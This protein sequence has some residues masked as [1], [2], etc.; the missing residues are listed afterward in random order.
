MNKHPESTTSQQLL[1]FV[2]LVLST[3]LSSATTA[4]D[5]AF[6]D[7]GGAIYGRPEALVTGT[8]RVTMFGR[9]TNDALWYR[10]WD[11]NTGQWAAWTSLGGIMKYNPAAVSYFVDGQ[12]I[13]RVFVT[14]KYNELWYRQRNDSAWGPWQ[15]LSGKNEVLLTPPGAGVTSNGKIAVC[16][17]GS[18]YRVYCKIWNGSQWSS[19]YDLGG[20]AVNKIEVVAW[21]T[22][23]LAVFTSWSS[24]RVWSEASGWSDWLSTGANAADSSFAVASSAPGRIDVVATVGDFGDPRPVFY[25]WFDG[26][27]WQ[28]Y[29]IGE[30]GEELDIVAAGAGRFSIFLQ[31]NESTDHDFPVRHRR[32]DG[33]NWLPWQELQPNNTNGTPA[34]AAFSDGRTHAFVQGPAH[35]SLYPVYSF[36][37]P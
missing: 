9:G 23:K 19:W 12:A 27:T 1:G 4:Q 31:T 14:G 13:T 25:R 34:A 5:Y 16:G 26:N 35:N 7:L 15:N 17:K 33:V 18:T 28:G 21:D 11:G 24:Y 20:G 3:S 32:F 2:L 37:F 30:A 22:G 8:N 10:D 36:Y 29:G 6:I